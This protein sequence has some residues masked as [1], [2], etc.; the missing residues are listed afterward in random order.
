M[1]KFGRAH[2]VRLVGVI[3]SFETLETLLSIDFLWRAGKRHGG[4]VR[5]AVRERGTFVIF[6]T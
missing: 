6:F 3:Q 1:C 5:Y 2:A 4:K